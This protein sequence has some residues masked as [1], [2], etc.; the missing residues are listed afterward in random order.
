MFVPSI[1]ERISLGPAAEEHHAFACAVVGKR[2]TATSRRTRIGDLCS[3]HPGR[4]DLLP[5]I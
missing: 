3:S 5:L 2:M 1:A 4:A